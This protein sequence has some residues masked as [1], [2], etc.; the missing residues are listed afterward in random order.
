MPQYKNYSFTS[1]N[2]DIDWEHLD[3]QAIDKKN[4]IKYIVYQGEYT[5]EKKKHIQ[6]Y[7]QF[8]QKKEMT[9]VKKLL[10]DNTLHLEN[11]KGTPQQNRDYCV[12]IEKEG[13]KQDTYFLPKEYGTIDL[14]TSGY[15]TDIQNIKQRIDDGETIKNIQRTA[16]NN[17]F[18]LTLKYNRLLTEYADDI[19]QEKQRE[20]IKDTFI[21]YRFNPV[22]TAIKNIVERETNIADT[23]QINWIYDPIGGT[24]KTHLARYLLTHYNSL[25]IT[26]GKV[27]DIHSIYNGEELVIFDLAR[28]YAEN[29]E[30]IYS[31]IETLKNGM[32]LSTKYQVKTKIFSKQPIILILANFK[33]DT[34]KLS[35]DRWNILYTEYIDNTL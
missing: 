25:Y 29:V 6:G 23:R 10:G 19:A 9:F 8:H 15:R 16:Q 12:K 21:D 14:I 31:V 7:I 33:P 17:E 24:G 34:S 35:Q 3:I 32:F 1:F 13:I 22:Q 20:I 2:T 27:A 4:A 28:T 26:G 5:K 11:A 18:E 30:H